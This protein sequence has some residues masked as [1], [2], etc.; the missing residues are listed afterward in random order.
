VLNRRK[1]AGIINVRTDEQGWFKTPL[2]AAQKA[3]DALICVPLAGYWAAQLE[4]V[5]VADAGETQAQLSVVPIADGHR[6]ALDAM[7][8]AA[9]PSNGKGV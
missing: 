4:A 9:V 2:P 1:G 5:A 7:L 6:D 3:I 8:K